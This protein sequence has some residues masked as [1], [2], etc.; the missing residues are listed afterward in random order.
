MSNVIQG[1]TEIAHRFAQNYGTM[2]FEQWLINLKYMHEYL[3]FVILHDLWLLLF[4][5]RDDPVIV[6]LIRETI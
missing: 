6:K 1:G 4:C 2:T 3:L 5:L